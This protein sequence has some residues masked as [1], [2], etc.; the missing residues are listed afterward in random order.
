MSTY[1]S[2]RADVSLCTWRRRG[3]RGRPRCRRGRPLCLTVSEPGLELLP[4]LVGQPLRDGLVQPRQLPLDL[5]Q[6][7]NLPV[8]V[9]LPV[10]KPHEELNAG[11]ARRALREGR[12][13]QQS[14]ESKARKMD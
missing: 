7:G 4:A 3:G 12:F 6:V 14:K 10:G 8:G 5:G 1:P 13:N 9:H 2:P 11:V